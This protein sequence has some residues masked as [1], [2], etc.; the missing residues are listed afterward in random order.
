DKRLY[1]KINIKFHVSDDPLH[2]VAR[3]TSIALK[4]ADKLPFLMR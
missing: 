4:N 1:D 2:A 3:G